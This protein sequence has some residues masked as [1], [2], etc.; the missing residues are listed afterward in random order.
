[1]LL[2][3]LL[4]FL[5]LEDLPV[6]SETATPEGRAGSSGNRDELEGFLSR[7]ARFLL[8]GSRENKAPQP[9][10]ARAENMTAEALRGLEAPPLWG[11]P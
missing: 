10:R 7:A 4:N 3:Q 6:S 9:G 1:M 8:E 2:R 5:H 11:P